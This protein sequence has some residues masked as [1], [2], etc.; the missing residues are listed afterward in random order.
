MDAKTAYKIAKSIPR[1]DEKVIT[2]TAHYKEDDT[3]EHVSVFNHG[4][5]EGNYSEHINGVSINVYNVKKE[6]EEENQ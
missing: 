6:F 5:E 4:T 1:T 3:L 2:I